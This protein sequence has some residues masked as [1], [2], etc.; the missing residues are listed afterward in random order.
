M[1]IL[2]VVGGVSGGVKFLEGNFLRV[3]DSKVS[4]LGFS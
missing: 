2:V 4:I 1:Y 3:R